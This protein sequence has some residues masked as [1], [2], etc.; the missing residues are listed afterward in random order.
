[1]LQSGHGVDSSVPA[2]IDIAG[3]SIETSIIIPAYNEES[4]LP[5]VLDSLRANGLFS[6]P[7][8][9]IVVDDGSID[10]TVGIAKEYPCRLLQHPH[11]RGKGCAIRTG[12]ISA[13]GKKVIFL[14][15][16]N[17]YPVESI[18]DFAKALDEYDLVRGARISDRH[19]MPLINRAGNIVF[20]GLI[21]IL[22]SV[23]DN[24]LLSGMYGARLDRLLELE[25]NTTGFE[26]EA[27]I[28][29]KSYAH[30]FTTT[31]IPIAYAVRAGVKKLKPFHDGRR[32]LY[33]LAQLA[34]AYNP[35]VMFVV[36]GAVLFLMG[37]L[38]IV[39]IIVGLSK[40]VNLPFRTNTTFMFG[41]LSM[42]GLQLITF[43]ISVHEAG[44]VYGLTGRSHQVL[45]RFIMYCPPHILAIVG[46][47]LASLGGLGVTWIIFSWLSDGMPPF[48][49]TITLTL[50]SLSLM[51]GIQLL[52]S[53]AFISALQGFSNKQ[54]EK[55]EMA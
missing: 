17:T 16:D 34:L 6:P 20:D 41:I 30:G 12:L 13:Q 26:I 4:G 28:V 44:T 32:I 29:A 21:Q 43:G 39:V 14:D 53:A 33:R 46:S 18:A 5:L 40:I 8:E 24:D 37:I 48:E 9:V 51:M 55:A 47:L 19:N 25:L 7:Y 49:G 22:H 52:T 1:M 31:T 36:P 42:I 38:G 10:N 27:E 15:A 54:Q 11:N 3:D 35:F 50:F 23:P 2:N 45:K